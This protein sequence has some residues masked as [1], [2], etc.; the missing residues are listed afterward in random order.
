MLWMP[1]WFWDWSDSSLW[2]SVLNCC[3]NGLV[4]KRNSIIHILASTYILVLM[5]G[6]N[7]SIFK[8]TVL[9]WQ[10]LE[11]PWGKHWAVL[12]MKSFQKHPVCALGR[13]ILFATSQLP[14]RQSPDC[15]H[16]FCLLD[17]GRL[18]IRF[19]PAARSSEVGCV[20]MLFPKF[21][22]SYRVSL[23]TKSVSLT[24]RNHCCLLQSFQGV[25]AHEFGVLLNL[26]PNLYSLLNYIMVSRALN[27]WL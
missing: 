25:T 7:N 9:W 22:A 15:S 17:Q 2:P 4:P 26:P 8:N 3:V 6:I 1:T 5:Q 21:L 11:S 27:L 10:Y 14:P 19:S 13:R 23:K 18:S 20:L 16:S 24:W 12:S